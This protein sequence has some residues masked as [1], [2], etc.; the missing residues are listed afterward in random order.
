MI[1]SAFF[2]CLTSALVAAW[3]CTALT[4]REYGT[5][6]AQQFVER[7]YDK[8]R[9]LKGFKGIGKV[10]FRRPDGQ[11]SS[12]VA[13][14]GLFPDK[15][16]VELFSIGQPIAKMAIDGQWFYLL[17]HTK[18]KF[19]KTESA[20]P[21]LKR[22]VDVPVKTRDMIALLSGRTPLAPFHFA[23]IRNTEEKTELTLKRWGR[24][25]QRIYLYPENAAVQTIQWLQSKDDIQWEATLADFRD[26]G[27][28]AIPFFLR[29]SDKEGAEF[30]IKVDRFWTDVDLDM[31]RF[32][33][34]SPD[35]VT[36]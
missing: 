24:T 20:N 28:W 10:V 9:G 4:V 8:N 1:R 15:L 13:W 11:Q 27:G 21:S 33:L 7:L 23:A 16:R 2:I 3:G 35:T 34:Q 32:S 18:N 5:P 19:Y 36:N 17:S 25:V 14:M 6:A 29:F 30:S 22:L 31:S 12:R 26:V